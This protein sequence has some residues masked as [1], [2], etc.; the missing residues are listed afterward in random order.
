LRN[1][2][3]LF[4]REGHGAEFFLINVAGRFFGGGRRFFSALIVFAWRARVAG[5]FVTRSLIAITALRFVRARGAHWRLETRRLDAAQRAAEFVNLAFVGNFLALG[6]LYKFENFVKLINGVLERF[7]D[8]RGVGY[9]LVDGR[10]FCRAKIGGL[11]PCSG[12][13]RFGTPWFMARRALCR[14]FRCALN[15]GRG[16]SGTIGGN[17]RNFFRRGIGMIIRM[18]FPKIAGIIADGFR[19]F[20]GSS[21][22][23]PGF[24]RGW[25]FF[26]DCGRFSDTCTRS[27]ASSAAPAPATSAGTPRGGGQIQIG[28]FVRHKFSGEDGGFACKCNREFGYFFTNRASAA[29]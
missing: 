11:G 1:D 10:S 28:L 22:N 5:F 29:V 23:F 6:Q 25:N 21:G 17:L 16:F 20:A 9:S 4:F 8:L 14:R 26:G 13:R 2:L 3:I 19:D 24:R 18:R 12:A 27:A 7:G 15:F